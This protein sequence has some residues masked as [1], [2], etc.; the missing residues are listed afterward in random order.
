MG[1]PGQTVTYGSFTFR[2]HEMAVDQTPRYGDNGIDQTGIRYTFKISGWLNGADQPSFAA[3]V[4][5]TQCQLAKPRLN[6]SVQWSGDSGQ[7]TLYSFNAATDLAWGPIPGA[8]NIT[9]IVAGRAA[10]FS[11]TLTCETKSCFDGSCSV[12]TTGPA[13]AVLSISFK[14]DHQIGPDGLTTRTVSGRLEITAAAVQQGITADSF[15]G[16]VTPSLPG[17]FQRD[18]EN[19][20]CSADG[21][22]LDFSITDREV[23][24]VLPAPVTT[25]QATWTVTVAP[26]GLT[27]TYR[28]A[29]KFTAPAS[30]T[31]QAIIDQILQLSANRFNV[32]AG[33]TLIPDDSMLEESIYENSVSF[34]MSAHSTAPVNA[35]SGS[36]GTLGGVNP[37]DPN[38]GFNTFGSLPPGS[39]SG[40]AQSIGAYGGAAG[41]ESSGVWAGVPT[42]YDACT[43][44]A[45]E[46][47]GGGGGNTPS[48][49]DST[50][51]PPDGSGSSDGTP[52]TPDPSSPSYGGVSSAHASLP[53]VMFKETISLECNNGF[54]SYYPKVAGAAPVFQQTRNPKVY[55][56]QSG[57]ASRSGQTAQDGPVIPS[58][59]YDT[60][61]VNILDFSFAPEDPQPIGSSSYSLYAVTWTY[62][63][64]WIGAI[65]ATTGEAGTNGFNLA[66]PED[67][68]PA[69]TVGGPLQNVPNAVQPPSDSDQ[70]NTDG[71]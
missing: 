61:Q 4:A 25:G 6:F 55:I 14:Y 36:S 26:Y 63:M 44:A 27:Q 32:P 71:L 38:T 51:P 12:N 65:T 1:V 49:G 3:L 11:W 28:L 42:P 18:G 50:N 16:N 10:M 68:R 5:Q 67:P 15:R 64:E 40:A 8:F 19:Y 59:M 13:S 70:A 48:G 46:S 17:Q 22:F 23:A 57:Y 58:P 21:R 34:S 62:R 54:V 56:I 33:I 41:G 29:G 20:Q 9:R 52:T 69:A 24:F 47:G 53:Y 39:A 30:V 31:K 45:S 43:P 7:T 35:G 37:F 60:S 2:Y 66:Y